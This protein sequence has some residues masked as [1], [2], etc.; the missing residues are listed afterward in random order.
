MSHSDSKRTPFMTVL[1]EPRADARRYASRLK[2]SAESTSSSI[3]TSVP[4]AFSGP[5]VCLTIRVRRSFH[6]ITIAV[7]SSFWSWMTTVRRAAVS[8]FRI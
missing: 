7:W 3:A 8:P 4:F 2:P 6:V 1:G 5:L